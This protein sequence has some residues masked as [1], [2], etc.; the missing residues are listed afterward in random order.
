M[1]VSTRDALL[2]AD[3]P[4]GRELINNGRRLAREITMGV[5]LLCEEFGVRSELA[6]K[7]LMTEQGR[8]MTTLNCGS[9][10]WADTARALRMIHQ[11]TTRRGF[12]IDRYQMQVDR[13]MGIPP[14]LR[15]RAAKETGPLLETD[16]DWYE[17]SHTVPIQPQLGD[18]MIGSPMSV[19]NAR[20]AL[21]AGVTYVGNMSQ[22][23]WKYPSWPGTDVDQ[24]IEMTK[25][26][27]IMA[28]KADEDAVMQSYLDDGFCAQFNDFSSYI[29]WAL[30]ERHIV[31]TLIGGRLSI[32][33]GGL[34]HN[35]I[36]KS[37][38]ILA[39]EAVKPDDTCTSFYHCN[40]T[41]YT[42]A[43][44]RNYAILGVDVLHLMLTEMKV[45]S[46][47]ATLPIPVTEALR[48]PTWQE[49]VEVHAISRRLAEFATVTF[50]TVDWR[51]V[52]AMAADLVE[53]GRR[54]FDNLMT[55]FEDLK[56][57]TS[58]PLQLL[59][60]AR[61]MGAVEIERR[62][63]AG[64]REELDGLTYEP[65]VPTDTLRDFLEQRDAVSSALAARAVMAD[66]HARIVVASTDV[67]EY[68]MRLVADALA[69]LGVEPIIAGVNVDPDE[70]ADLAVEAGA[71]ALLVSTHNGM[72]LTY[73]EQLKQ[74]LES[75]RLAPLMVFGGTLN[76]DFEGSDSPLDVR[77]NLRAL[78]VRCCN[79]VAEVVDALG[80]KWGAEGEEMQ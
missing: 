29:G 5:S 21:E 17:T 10:T 6:Y 24:M 30:F 58:D 71:T 9:Q 36:T 23:S 59:L 53:G 67:H 11:E 25:A 43:I 61:R 44:E 38:M 60:A 42:P 46:G 68:G 54:F 62:F 55:G 72:A 26:L 20:K 45:R 12:R 15:A 13:R 31:N 48:I 73:A 1:P 57:D 56:V 47:A 78:G 75:R 3:L 18:M 77:D 69:T 74:E 52:E 51:P 16:E 80:F 40:T 27:G 22:F 41:A 19:H 8:L 4:D 49:I 7:R 79:N 65:L 32:A 70:L 66:P 50:E 37:A 35:P 28:A 34:T 14:E 76:Q 2:P 33:Y 39:L 64:Q 63:G